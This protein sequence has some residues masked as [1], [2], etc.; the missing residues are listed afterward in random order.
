MNTL[1]P[2]VNFSECVVTEVVLFSIVAFKTPTFHKVTQRHTW[3][4]MQS[5]V[6]VSLWI[7]FENRL[8]F[9]K[10]KAYKMVPFWPTL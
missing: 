9:D 10:V 3:D 7:F 8:I 5:I 4:V 1:S 2:V 6:I